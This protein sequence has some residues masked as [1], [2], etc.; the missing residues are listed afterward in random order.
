MHFSALFT[1]KYFLNFT[2]FTIYVQLFLSYRFCHLIFKP[3]IFD[4]SYHFMPFLFLNL[5]KKMFLYPLQYD[6]MIKTLSKN[7]TIN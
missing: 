3:P 5:Y 2:I 4:I 6:K 1:I 7:I